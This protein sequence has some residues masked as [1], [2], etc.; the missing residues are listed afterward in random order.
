MCIFCF[1]NRAKDCRGPHQ[2]I[3]QLIT[4]DHRARERMQATSKPQGQAGAAKRGRYVY[5]ACLL[6]LCFHSK[7]KTLVQ[8]R[9]MIPG[10][11]PVCFFL[12][13]FCPLSTSTISYPHFVFSSIFLGFRL[14]IQPQQAV[15]ALLYTPNTSAHLPA[16]T[17]CPLLVVVVVWWWRR[18]ESARAT[19]TNPW[20]LQ[21]KEARKP[22]SR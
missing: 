21:L 11:P 12:L 13:L 10:V 16:A 1:D 9:G 18:V 17:L 6:E 5:G 20:S 3:N 19:T 2:S 22:E 7:L 8:A 14:M 4:A 15:V